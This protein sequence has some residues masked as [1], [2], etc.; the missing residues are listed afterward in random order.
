MPQVTA[1]NAPAVPEQAARLAA[2]LA[3]GEL[4]GGVFDLAS[5]AGATT[6]LR[7]LGPAE[8]ELD[9]AAPA[10]AELAADNPVLLDERAARE[11]LRRAWA[12]ARPA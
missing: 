8:A 9:R 3:A 7:D 2:A 10:V 5:R 1:L 6:A 4:A 12:G 11:L